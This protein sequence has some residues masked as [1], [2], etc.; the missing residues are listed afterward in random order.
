M[1]GRQLMQDV[2]HP[3]RPMSL[4]DELEV[5]TLEDFRSP[6]RT[7]VQTAQKILEKIGLLAEESFA[8]RSQ[9]VGAWRRSQVHQL[10]LA[11]GRDSME[12][13]VPIER[14]VEERQR[15]GQQFL[16]PDEFA[17]VADLN[18]QLSM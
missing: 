13:G 14:I 5:L 4:V 12:R 8:K 1:D 2:K 11:M 10:Y 17:I 6:S 18:R 9:G 3:V 7:V 16:T 15:A